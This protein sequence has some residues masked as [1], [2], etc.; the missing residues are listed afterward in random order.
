MSTPFPL[1]QRQYTWIRHV[2]DHRV[3]P[4]K[5]IGQQE[6]YSSSGV[7]PLFSDVGFIVTYVNFIADH[8]ASGHRLPDCSTQ[9][10]FLDWAPGMVPFCSLAS[11]QSVMDVLSVTIFNTYQS[12][13]FVHACGFILA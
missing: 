13:H 9:V 6:P 11:T 3:L 2:E 4:Y 5:A 1:R 12:G 10:S 7:L 8:D